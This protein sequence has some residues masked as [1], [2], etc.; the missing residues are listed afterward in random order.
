MTVKIFPLG[1]N[2]LP[3]MIDSLIKW[4]SDSQ[5]KM[6]RSHMLIPIAEQKQQYL[7]FKFQSLWLR[8]EKTP[9]L[10]YSLLLCV[11][12]AWGTNYVWK[13]FVGNCMYYCSRTERSRRILGGNSSVSSCPHTHTHT[14][15]SF[16]CK[17]GMAWGGESCDSETLCGW[18]GI[19]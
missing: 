12:L 15:I 4:L 16:Q 11:R 19:G 9:T 7:A 2:K 17:W 18:R 14:H 8:K 3:A 13:W 5:P 1:K 10:I 6:S